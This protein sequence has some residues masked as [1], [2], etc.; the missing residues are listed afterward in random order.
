M[1]HPPERRLALAGPSRVESVNGSVKSVISML[2]AELG[3]SSC[4]RSPTTEL[5]VADGRLSAGFGVAASD[6]SVR[7]KDMRDVSSEAPDVATK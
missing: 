4:D 5:G 7:C 3:V 6:V 2:T 1:R